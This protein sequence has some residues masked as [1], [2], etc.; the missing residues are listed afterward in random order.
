MGFNS[1]QDH[2]ENMKLP[3][4]KIFRDELKEFFDPSKQGLIKASID[5]RED[6]NVYHF[7]FVKDYGDW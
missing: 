1:S 5:P 2:F 7:E 4:Y 6:V 3:G